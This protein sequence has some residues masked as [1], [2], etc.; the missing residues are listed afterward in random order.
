MIKSLMVRLLNLKVVLLLA[1]LYFLV[2][3]FKTNA[4]E[5]SAKA[6]SAKNEY[7]IGDKISVTLDIR[8]PKNFSM[9]WQRLDPEQGKLELADSITSDSID[10]GQFIHTI[11]HLPLEGF[12]SG[13]VIYPEQVFIFKKAGDT[14]RFI[15]KTQPLNFH[16]ITISVDLK[17][18]IKPIAEPVKA[19]L[20]WVGFGLLLAIISA[21]ILTVFLLYLRNRKKE[22]EA[23][24]RQPVIRRPPWE[25]AIEKLAELQKADL[26]G[27]GQV[28]GYYISL[29]AILRQFVNGM[30]QIDAL[31]LTTDEVILSM[32]K[33]FISPDII[34]ALSAILNL[35]DSVKFAKYIPGEADHENA[36][37]GAIDFIRS[38]RENAA[39][40]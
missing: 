8:R 19:G 16:V 28:K 26:P 37:T 5:I 30:Y 10:E 4:Q 34:N 23:F 22:K 11:I 14:S 1:G 13:N 33:K 3:P 9:A 15:V 27:S 12:D 18:D 24:S 31:E 32:H 35:S 21:V 25:I 40:A 38:V 2:N 7:L 36:M 6:T 39:L 29:S 20:D 17:K